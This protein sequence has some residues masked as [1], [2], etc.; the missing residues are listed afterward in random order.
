MY[1]KHDL[2]SNSNRIFYFNL[3]RYSNPKLNLNYKPKF[4]LQHNCDLKLNF[5]FNLKFEL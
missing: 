5:K 4:D 2:T 1:L 3:K